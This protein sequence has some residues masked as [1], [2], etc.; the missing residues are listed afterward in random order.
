MYEYYWTWLFL[1]CSYFSNQPN[2]LFFFFFLNIG[3]SP[4]TSKCS[5]EADIELS[6]H[7]LSGLPGALE[8][9]SIRVLTIFGS[10][11]VDPR[12]ILIRFAYVSSTAP[13]WRL[14][15]FLWSRHFFSCL[16]RVRPVWIDLHKY[17]HENYSKCG[18]Q[19]QFLTFFILE[20]K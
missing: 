11:A 16:S 8:V 15:K 12:H 1:C 5:W 19:F 6:Y 9:F 20:S 7:L 17:Q 13:H 10:L 14:R 3:L 4:I 18:V 2:I